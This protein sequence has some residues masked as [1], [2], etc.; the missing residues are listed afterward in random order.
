[1]AGQIEH[2]RSDLERFLLVVG[3]EQHQLVRARIDL[4][5][6]PDRHRSDVYRG[7]YFEGLPRFRGDDGRVITRLPRWP[8]F[9]ARLK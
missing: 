9:L 7:L 2:K 1:M 6:R 8:K 4:D 5:S 3:L